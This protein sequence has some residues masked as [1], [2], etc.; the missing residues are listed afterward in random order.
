MLPGTY[1]LAD[2][3]ACSGS[4]GIHGLGWPEEVRIGG[5]S[6]AQNRVGLRA[7]PGAGGH[8]VLRGP[9]GRGQ[10]HGGMLSRAG[11][12]VFPA[13]WKLAQEIVR[14]ERFMCISTNPFPSLYRS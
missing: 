13:D 4:R 5:S 10:G 9:V 7:D 3:W 11:R 8:G 2:G 12:F 6:E 14:P 1:S